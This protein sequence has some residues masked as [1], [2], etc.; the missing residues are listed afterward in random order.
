M[1]LLQEIQT[2]FPDIQQADIVR[3]LLFLG[4]TPED[5]NTGKTYRLIQGAEVILPMAIVDD[6]LDRKKH[7][8][9]EN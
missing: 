1:T 5:M 8:Q 6:E 4:F 7:E 2:A 3:L 9:P